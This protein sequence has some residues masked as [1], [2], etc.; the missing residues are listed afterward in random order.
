MEL[1]P[2]ATDIYEVRFIEK[3]RHDLPIQ[4]VRTSSKPVDKFNNTKSIISACS[5]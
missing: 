4:F 5:E 3:K 1:E 2:G